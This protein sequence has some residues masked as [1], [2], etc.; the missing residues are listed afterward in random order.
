VVQLTS[1]GT[2]T[3]RFGLCS[4]LPSPTPT[5]TQTPSPTPTQ[6]QTP[7]STLTPTPTET[8]T[9]TPTPTETQTPTP[10]NTETPTETPTN[11]PTPTITPT[12]TET[13]TNTPTNTQTPTPT[14]T[15]TPTPTLTP[16]PT[17]VPFYAYILIDT[18]GTQAKANLSSWM[19]SQGS[20]WRGFNQVGSPSSVQGTFDAQMNAYLAYS[21]W[22]GNLGAGDEPAIIQSPICLGGCSGND[23]YGNLII[24]NVFETVQIPTGAFTATTNNWTTVFVPTGATPGQKYSQVKNGISAGAMTAKNMNTTY[25][26]LIINYSGSTNIPAGVYRMYST[27]AATDFRLSTSLLPNYFQGGTLVSA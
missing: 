2:E 12:N 26:S 19:T 7:T 3:C 21:G 5:P 9:N 8:P 25:N 11:T 20:V 16:T 24:Q 23:A 4:N 13:P 6:T 27:Y 15:N 14:N 18:N 17:N 10:T 1:G 22:T